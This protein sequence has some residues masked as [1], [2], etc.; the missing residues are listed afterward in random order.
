MPDLSCTSLR[1]WTGKQLAID[2][3][4]VPMGLQETLVEPCNVYKMVPDQTKAGGM[5]RPHGA[6]N[7]PQLL[8]VTCVSAS[9][10]N[11]R[12]AYNQFR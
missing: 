3:D 6:K 1:A 10:Q 7:M 2:A 5:D 8:V 9:H 4:S 11:D 12:A